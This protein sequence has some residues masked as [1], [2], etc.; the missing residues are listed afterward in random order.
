M[1]QSESEAPGP[2]VSGPRHSKPKSGDIEE[3]GWLDNG[4]MY[5]HQYYFN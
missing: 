4:M 1:S 2:L 3:Y 5:V